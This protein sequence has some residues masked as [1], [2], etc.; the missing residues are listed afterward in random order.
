MHKIDED[1][2][3]HAALPANTGQADEALHTR[4]ALMKEFDVKFDGTEYRH[5][6]QRFDSLADALMHARHAVGEAATDEG[7]RRV[8]TLLRAPAR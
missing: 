5:G 6:G 2:I 7:F 8:C 4:D 3:E 1:E